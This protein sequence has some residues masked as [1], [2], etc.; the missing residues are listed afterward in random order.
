MSQLAVPPQQYAD[1]A[2]KHAVLSQ[3]KSAERE[4]LTNAARGDMYRY[5]DTQWVIASP[6]PTSTTDTVCRG[7][8]RLSPHMQAVGH[9][10]SWEGVIPKTTKDD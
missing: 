10:V 1:R 4:V 9:D 6:T 5:R 8:G 7:F 2:I 3:E